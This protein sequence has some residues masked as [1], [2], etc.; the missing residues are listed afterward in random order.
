MV[1]DGADWQS[2]GDV[3]CIDRDVAIVVVL[4]MVTERS[5]G[6]QR[7]PTPPHV[8][9][10]VGVWVVNAHPILSMVIV[11]FDIISRPHIR[12]IQ[13]AG[14]DWHVSVHLEDQLYLAAPTIGQCGSHHHQL[15]SVSANLRPSILPAPPIE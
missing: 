9:A 8:D 15:G 13:D 11:G 5:T 7:A 2:V 1:E 10:Q 3:N 12:T 14:A 6:Y 4:H